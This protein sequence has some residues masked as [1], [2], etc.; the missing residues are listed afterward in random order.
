MNDR[1]IIWVSAAEPSADLHG[2]NLIKELKKFFSHFKFVGIGGFRMRKEGLK[3][4]YPA[5]D[6]S[7]M[8]LIEV[9]SFIPKI[10][11]LYGKIREFFKNF[12]PSFL[13]LIDAP[14]FHFKIAK[15]AYSLDIPVFYYIS[16]QVWAWRKSRI[17]FLK[18]YVKKLFCIFPFEEE[19]FKR[20]GLDVE[21]VGHPL[22]EEMDFKN[23]ALIKPV[24]R[25]IILLPG[26]RKKEVNSLM[27]EFFKASLI[28]KSK[29][30][31]S[32]FTLIKASNINDKDIFR[33]W[34]R[35]KL[36]LELISRDEEKYKKMKEGEVAIAAS[37]TATLECGLLNLPCVVTYKVSHLSYLI[38]KWLVN[39]KYISMTNIILN[40][41]IFPE[42][43]QD[44]ANGKKI[45]DQI[46]FWFKKPEILQNI[47]ARLEDLKVV[48]GNKK[49]SYNCA[50]SIW[51]CVCKS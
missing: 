38:A 41:R 33:L 19:F 47:R 43:I 17:K 7:V 44:E 16:P 40:D 24:K 6:L 2:S 15:M 18:K 11:K 45:A 12:N 9:I 31:D 42:F 46:L 3:S 37:G 1:N 10:F 13:V 25:K 23:L 35:K 39:A 48:I 5:E 8:G 29:Y 32:S 30:P 50:K 34:D 28:I 26:S 21:Y 27:P 4:L 49:A 20:Y 22:I 51:E 14:D 36:P